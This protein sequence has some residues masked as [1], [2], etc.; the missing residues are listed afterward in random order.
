M[1]KFIPLFLFIFL[2]YSCDDSSEKGNCGNGIVDIGEECDPEEGSMKSC[3][4]AGYY[5]NGSTLCT[6]ECT[7]DY[8]QCEGF[9]G[10]G[11]IQGSEDCDLENLGTMSLCEDHEGYSGNTTVTCNSSCRYDLSSCEKLCGNGEIDTGEECDSDNLNG[12]TDCSQFGDY[13][14]SE[15]V[16]CTQTCS[17]DLSECVLESCG[18]G[19]VDEGEECEVEDIGDI[20]CVSEGF[21]AGQIQCTNC[22]INTSNCIGKC[23]DGTIQANNGEECDGTNLGGK[24]CENLNYYGGELVCTDSCKLD[25]SSCV[26]EGMCGDTIIQT[27]YNEDCD[28]DNLN[29]MTCELLGHTYGGNLSCTSACMFNETDCLGYCGDEQVQE[30]EGEECDGTNLNGNDSCSIMGYFNPDDGGFPIACSTGCLL[31]DYGC[32][33]FVQWGSTGI[34]EQPKMAVDS[35]GNLYIAGTALSTIN[36]I[37]VFGDTDIFL[38]KINTFGEVLWTRQLG[39]LRNDFLKGITIDTSENIILTGSTTGIISQNFN[40]MGNSTG[41]SDG[42]IIK[43]TSEGLFVNSTQWGSL[44]SYTEATAITTDSSGNIYVTGNTSGNLFS[45]TNSGGSDIFIAKYLPS[46]VI[47]ES[48]LYGSDGGDYPTAIYKGILTNSVTITGY[49]D[50]EMQ[51]GVQ[52]GN[53]DIFVMRLNSDFLTQFWVKQFG[54]DSNDRALAMATDSGD[55][56]YISGA[57]QGDMDGFNAGTDDIF[58]MKVDVSGNQ[59]WVKQIGSTQPDEG[60]S[61]GV[62]SSGNVYVGGFTMGILDGHLNIGD[63][64]IILIKL[65]S[66]GE[67]LNSGHWGSTSDDICTSLVIGPDQKVYLAG[68]TLGDLAPNTGGLIDIWASRPFPL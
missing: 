24:S 7:I 12:K 30:S 35:S 18:N 45:Q 60:S 49:T 66:V 36:G 4:Q 68:Q 8:S 22:R 2:S 44:S 9:C 5:G 15:T 64:D 54:S 58:V 62:D 43:T 53:D 25:S 47:S 3:T 41:D 29:S 32:T 61:I 33:N 1:K 31:M 67:I 40:S 20:T 57:T 63:A 17:Y 56:M 59:D 16:S 46:L 14:P 55:N 37:P 28:G 34:E 21:Y 50:G 13:K 39:S 27:A 6:S 23:G 19:I 26:S 10:D 52:F 11:Q 38:T 42:F 51:T 48:K 65:S